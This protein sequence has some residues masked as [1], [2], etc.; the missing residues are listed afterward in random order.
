MAKQYQVC[1]MLPRAGI[2]GALG[3][4]FLRV[5][6]DT[7]WNAKVAGTL[8]LTRERLDF[9][10]GRGGKVM[11]LDKKNPIPRR[12]KNIFKEHGLEDP[13]EGLGKEDRK[14]RTVADF[15]IQGSRE[16][17]RELAFGHQE[18]DFTRGADNSKVTRQPAIEQWAVD[19]Y[20]FMAKKYG[21]DN[22]AYFI[23]HLDETNPHV[24]CGVV[25][26]TESNKL[27]FNQVFG[28]SKLE[29]RR[30]LLKLHDELY[31][32][33]GK[34]YELSRGESILKTGAQ[35]K[36]YK[37]WL[38]ETIKQ[39]NEVMIDNDISIQDQREMLQSLTEEVKKAERRQKGL[40]TMLENL[41]FKKDA[42]EFELDE[43]S[44]SVNESETKNDELEAKLRQLRTEL[45][46][47]EDKIEERKEQLR[48]A[49]EQLQAV[50]DRQAE[51]QNKYDEMVRAINDKLP[52]LQAK[53]YH[54]MESAAWKAIATEAM[55]KSQEMKDFA[56]SLSY[57]KEEEFNN[58]LEGSLFEMMSEKAGEIVAV[59]SAL[60]LGYIDQATEYAAQC[61][62][63]G[64]S[65]GGGWGRKK[66][67]DDDTFR[68]RC[69][70]ASV[71][72]LQPDSSKVNLKEG[73][74]KQRKV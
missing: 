8:D 62:G 4:E 41:Q 70:F 27:S 61:G 18:V 53:V 52:D 42:I 11:E 14:R 60:F 63:G 43:I 65:P 19:T 10:I 74:K 25:P 16:R 1:D 44:R 56:E 72:M 2:D 57:E 55:E 39:Q 67:E 31:E 21:E 73:R 38:E 58:I 66:D 9:E 7:A 59:A 71:N 20:N 37:Q 23:V 69:L 50:S 30:K 6:K 32:S 49:N 29:G 68:R 45:Q 28:G 64:G 15:V 54:E 12:I 35:H 13:N 34:K 5:G 47:T 40:T 33:V 36:S 24:H 17:M 22:I 51:L 26:I 48:V 3:H 46:L